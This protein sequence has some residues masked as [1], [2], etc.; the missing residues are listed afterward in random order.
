MSNQVNI[1][2]VNDHFEDFIF[3]WDHKYYFLVGG[4][5]SSKSFHV[6][7]KILLK[8]LEEKRKVLVVREVYQTIK[9]SCYSL[10]K[11]VAGLLGVY[12]LIKWKSSPL[13]INFPNGSQII[14][15]GCD[16]PEKLKSI[17]DI[18]IIWCEECSEIKF[19][20]FKELKGR[21]R[22]NTLSN[23]II[24]STNP[25][26]TDNWTY[27]HFFKDEDNNRVVLDDNDLYEKRT[28]ILGNTYYHHSTCDDNRYV[29]QEYKDELDEIKTYDMDL[30]RVARLGHYGAN[31]E[32][33]LPQFEVKDHDFIMESI[34]KIPK[35][36]HKRGGDFGFITSFNAFVKV[37]IDE[38][39]KALY[40]YDVYYKKGITDDVLVKDLKAAGF[41]DGRLVTCDIAEQKTISYLQKNGIMA[42]GCK[43]FA[44]SVLANIKKVKRF[45]KIYCSEECK[46]VIKELQNLTYK[47]DRKGNLIE[48][49]FNIDAHT[50]YI[51]LGVYKSG[52]KTGTL[53]SQSEWK[54]VA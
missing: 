42:V 26:G 33:V 28:V 53:R 49:E 52:K 15:R 54:A 19:A 40:I 4:Y 30:W 25:V 13:E 20:G 2:T 34:K 29:P 38:K 21:L 51:T 18:S 8:C 23:H 12:D 27:T 11:N 17:D 7:T 47:K 39:E 31:G 44:G 45:K 3:N 35:H 50:F 24:L 46:P 43:K 14:F 37:A 9:D 16:D 41:K 10:F 6:A 1:F 48:N 36:L 32:K 22:H 5:G